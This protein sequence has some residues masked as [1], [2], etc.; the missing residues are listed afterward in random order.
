MHTNTLGKIF[1]VTAVAWLAGKV[2]ARAMDSDDSHVT[3]FPDISD[4]VKTYLKK[5]I[6]ND[7]KGA[8]IR[9]IDDYVDREMP[10]Q[11]RADLWVA[12]KG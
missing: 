7:D 2:V 11:T 4:N 5:C 1:G 6:R 3:T 8:F 10:A 9:A 12:L